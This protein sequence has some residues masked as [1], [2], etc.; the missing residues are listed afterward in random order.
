[1]P[2][3]HAYEKLHLYDEL[4]GRINLCISDPE[5]PDRHI[6]TVFGQ[7]KEGMKRAKLLCESWNAVV[8]VAE[9]LDADPLQVAKQLQCGKISELV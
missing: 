4:H 2:K 3:K 5:N 9:R 8:S 6:G 1:M 7:Q